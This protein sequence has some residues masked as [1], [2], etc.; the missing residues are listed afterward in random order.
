M[1]CGLPARQIGVVSQ[2]T[3]FL[4]RRQPF[5]NLRHDPISGEIPGGGFGLTILISNGPPRQEGLYQAE[6]GDIFAPPKRRTQLT[7]LWS[8]RSP[9]RSKGRGDGRGSEITGLWHESS[10][11]FLCLDPGENTNFWTTHVQRNK[12]P[13]AD[14]ASRNSTYDLNI[15][16]FW[17]L[18]QNQTR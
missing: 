13:S 15:E 5:L 9:K 3:A 17:G 1:G 16:A 2:I 4:Q 8:G 7:R 14:D 18:C 10:G 11:L 12:S 6:S